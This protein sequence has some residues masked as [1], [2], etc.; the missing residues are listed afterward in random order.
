VGNG[1]EL[2]K[3]LTAYRS[4]SPHETMMYPF[5]VFIYL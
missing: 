1:I 4:F 5:C 2:F 3:K